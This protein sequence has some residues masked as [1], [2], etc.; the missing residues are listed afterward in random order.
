MNTEQKPR[1]PIGLQF[2]YYAD[3]Q[4]RV[5]TILNIYTTRNV[6]GNVVKIEY[7]VEHEFCGQRLTELMIDTAI[8]RS[9]G[10]EGIKPYL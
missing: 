1:F 7:L 9:L 8:A 2:V 5:H 4:K 10:N 3:K 6:A